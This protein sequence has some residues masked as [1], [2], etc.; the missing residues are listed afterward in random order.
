MYVQ[1]MMCYIYTKTHLILHNIYFTLY[2]PCFNI[3]PKYFM[4]KD[5]IGVSR[6]L[7]PQGILLTEHMTGYFGFSLCHRCFFTIVIG[8][9]FSYF[10]IIYPIP[11]PWD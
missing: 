9:F 2:H 3:F 7:P 4:I 5:I 10:F 11:L 1:A 6:S 8:H